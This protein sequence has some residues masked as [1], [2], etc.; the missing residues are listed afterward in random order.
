MSGNKTVPTKASVE[1]FIEAVPQEEKRNDCFKLLEVMQSITGEAPVMWGPGIIG[2]GSY[3]YRYDSGREGDM[4]MTGFSP[5]SQNISLYIM[6]GFGRYESLLKK[7][8]K[9]KTGKSCLYV[10]R[11]SDINME[12]LEELIR[13]S[14]NHCKSKYNS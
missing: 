4:L 8:G 12:I 9:Y 6:S 1:A 10:K 7:L 13:D 3:H 2:F 5:R 11:L 14:Y